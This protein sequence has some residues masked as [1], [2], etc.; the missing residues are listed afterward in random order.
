MKFTKKL[1]PILIVCCLL[2]NATS[3]FALSISSKGGFVLNSNTGQEVYSQRGDTP[4]VPAS[5]TKVMS[6]YVIYE[7]MEDGK[8][9]KDTLISISPALATF[10][11][12]PGYSNVTLSS[13]ASYSLDE[14]L[15]AIF[16]VSA[17][18][19]VMA[20]GDYI[21]GS[22]SAFVNRMNQIVAEWGIDAWFEDCTGVSSRNKVTPRAMATIANRLATDYPDCLNY[23]SKK[24]INFRGQTYYATNKMLPG[25]TY[26]YDGAMGLKTGTTSAAGACFTGLVDRDG[27]RMISVV[28][29]APY[30][31]C[32]YTDSIAML[33]YA[34][35]EI[36]TISAPIPN[37]ATVVPSTSFYVNDLPIPGF[38]LDDTYLIRAEDLREYGFDVNYEPETD[39][40]EII[41]RTDKPMSG[42]NISDFPESAELSTA[43]AVN[44]LIKNNEEDL[45]IYTVTVYDLSGEA[46][47]DVQE[48]AYLGWVIQKNGV[49]TIV[50]R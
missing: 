21:Y 5:M 33:D 48:L 1:I 22:E 19:A 18:A 14:L 28:M 4:M 43:K 16:V 32:R 24:S 44:V 36:G 34:F 38:V 27:V 10:S 45:G 11:R 12:N 39:T 41:N 46:A 17:N 26:A 37:P 15:D 2:A 25:R 29:G 3:A 9:S 42:L 30:S 20:V 40:L 50:T 49:A 31:N 13:G 35:S 8:L 23:S 47:I 6:A 7:A